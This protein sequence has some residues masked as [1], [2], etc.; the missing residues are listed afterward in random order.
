METLVDFLRYV[1]DS[2]AA[3]LPEEC[4]GRLIHLHNKVTQIKSSEQM[5]VT[6]MKM[7]ER[8]RLIQERGEEIGLI[9]GRTE[10]VLLGKTA[11]LQN[12]IK[13]NRKDNIPDTEINTMLQK[14]FQLTY[15]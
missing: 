3:S 4:D 6:Y 13:V 10:G 15:K 1:A 9:K 12:F 2:N 11:T 5:E 7:E 8:D 14:Y